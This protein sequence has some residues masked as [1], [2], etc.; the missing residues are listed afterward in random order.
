MERVAS[1]RRVEHLS[2][3]PAHPAALL[4]SSLTSLSWELGTAPSRQ[5]NTAW[6]SPANG[7]N[8]QYSKVDGKIEE[9]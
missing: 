9:L 7:H 8:I 1:S 5:G 3:Q 2:T 6:S 4:S